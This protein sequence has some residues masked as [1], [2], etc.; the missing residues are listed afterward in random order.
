[1]R[2]FE[3]MVCSPRRCE[4]STRIPLLVLAIGFVGTFF[5]PPT[6]SAEIIYLKN[7]RKIVADIVREDARQIF[8]SR[9]GGE[10][11]IPRSIVDRIEKNASPDNGSGAETVDASDRA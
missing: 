8:V 11:A 7:G 2:G 10:Y 9:G 3:K 1:M 6:L 4:V 5:H